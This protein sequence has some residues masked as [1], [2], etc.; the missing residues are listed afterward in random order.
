MTAD[1]TVSHPEHGNLSV[2]LPNSPET[3]LIEYEVCLRRLRRPSLE[4]NRSRTSNVLDD[5]RLAFLGECGAFALTFKFSG[6]CHDDKDAG[7]SPKFTMLG[8]SGR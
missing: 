6:R 1:S 3:P 4:N 8:S 7:A 5:R 2:H